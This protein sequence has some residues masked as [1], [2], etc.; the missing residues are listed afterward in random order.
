MARSF[1]ARE[2]SGSA[3][4]WVRGFG[5]GSGQLAFAFWFRN[6][7]WRGI[8]TRDTAQR[9]GKGGLEHGNRNWV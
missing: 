8:C 1:M 3:W 9:G 2:I 6:W 4:G 5:T 7:V